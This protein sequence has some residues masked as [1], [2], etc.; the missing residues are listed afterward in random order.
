MTPVPFKQANMTLGP[1]PGTEDKV[2]PLPVFND[3]EHTTS[4]WM[5]SPE[6]LKQ[7]SETGRIYVRVWAGRSSPPICA[8]AFNPVGEFHH[9]MSTDEYDSHV[10][11]GH[12][13]WCGGKTGWRAISG[14]TVN[15]LFGWQDR[16]G[17]TALDVNVDV[18]GPTLFCADCG[19]GVYNSEPSY[20]PIVMKVVM[21]MAERISGVPM[22]H[23]ESP[24]AYEE[25]LKQTIGPEEHARIFAEIRNSL[26]G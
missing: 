17:Q 23:D 22:T 16:T 7:V 24:E 4:C 12:C 26:H 10:A 15:R 3:G 5:L 25:R 19:C 1:A 14:K 20:N 2:T 11:A 21:D 18:F 8:A 13:P 6:E 9:E